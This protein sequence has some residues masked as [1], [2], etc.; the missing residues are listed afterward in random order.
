MPP[1]PAIFFDESRS[2]A[3]HSQVKRSVAAR[4]FRQEVQEVPLRHE[5]HEATPRS[6]IRHLTKDDIVASDT[7]AD[8]HEFLMRPL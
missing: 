6:E 3:L 2:L 1:D 5:G 8:L 4:L 7:G